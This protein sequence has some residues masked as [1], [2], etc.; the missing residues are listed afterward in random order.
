MNSGD[1]CNI[2][3]RHGFV[4]HVREVCRTAEKI[5]NIRSGTANPGKLTLAGALTIVAAIECRSRPFDRAAR[6]SATEM[7]MPNGRHHTIGW[8]GAGRMGYQIAERLLTGGCDVSIWNRTR[9]KAQPL[10]AAGAAI[11]D[12]PADLADR[13]IVFTMVAGSDDFKQVVMGPSGVLSRP[14]VAPAIIVDASTISAGASDQVRTAARE[15]GTTLVAAPVSGNPKVVAAGR[16]TVV[17]SGPRQAYDT[18]LPYLELFGDGVTYV[19]EG[20]GARLVKICH[21]L[22]LGVVAQ[23]LAEIAVLAEKGGVSRRDCLAFINQ[24]VMGSTFSRYKTPAYVNQDYAPT[25]TP[26]LLRKDFDLGIAAADELGVPLRTMRLI[27]GLVQEMI[28]A[29][30]TDVD[31]AALIEMEAAGAGFALAVDSDP[32]DDGLTDRNPGAIPA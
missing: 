30:R 9:S 24:S 18:V 3:H 5:T 4:L 12:S 17:V 6:R 14:D 25:F 16:L 20:D 15:R 32:V 7:T 26:E 22:L 21:N 11:V 29:G 8:I 10:E 23:S 28:D 27:R 1:S 2:S 13:D 31:F 19:G